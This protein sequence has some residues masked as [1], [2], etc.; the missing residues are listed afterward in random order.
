MND[1]AL[2]AKEVRAAWVGGE[3]E[4][5]VRS[6][7]R[8]GCHIAVF[9]CE[10]TGLTCLRGRDFALMELTAIGGVQVAHSCGAVA[11]NHRKSVDVIY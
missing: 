8:R 1:D 2:V 5:S 4:V 3:I 11:V 10:I 6:C 9:S 7:E